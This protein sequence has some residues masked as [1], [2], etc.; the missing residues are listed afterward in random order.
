MPKHKIYFGYCIDTRCLNHHYNWLVLA[1]KD[2]ED[3]GNTKCELCGSALVIR[4]SMGE[5]RKAYER[6]YHEGPSSRR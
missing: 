5:L 3:A 2:D 1:A 6:P 4:K